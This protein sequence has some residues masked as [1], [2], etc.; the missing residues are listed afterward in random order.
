VATSKKTQE[1]IVTLTKEKI[2]SICWKELLQISMNSSKARSK[3]TSNLNI[4]T[5]KHSKKPV[6]KPIYLKY[7]VKSTLNLPMSS[8][9]NTL[10]RKNGANN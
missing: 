1:S 4:T 7:R 5:K 3:I 10:Y 6:T 9:T 8:V 2:V